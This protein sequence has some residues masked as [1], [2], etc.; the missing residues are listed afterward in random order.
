MEK[1]F[2]GEPLTKEDKLKGLSLGVAQGSVVPVFALSGLTGQGVDMLLDFIK[3]CCPAPKSE[4]AVDA[5]G[6]PVEISV[7]ENAPLAAVCFKTVADPFIGKLN[8][9]KAVS[10]KI[11]Q[12]K[13]VINSRTGKSERVGKIVNMLGIK[14]SE[15]E[16]ISAGEI[17]AVVKLDGFKT[18]V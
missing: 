12:G 3:D 9:F 8:Y 16:K 13:T 18:G 14:Q 2:D 7:D 5:E 4:Y 10:G 15:A 6:E 11:V 17:G 1:Y